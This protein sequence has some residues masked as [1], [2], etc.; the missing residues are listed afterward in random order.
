[1]LFRIARHRDSH[2]P[3]LAHPF[4]R[5]NMRHQFVCVP[6]AVLRRHERRLA[7]RRIAPQCHDPA[8]AYLR[9]VPTADLNTTFGLSIAVF[10]LIQVF[11]ISHKG[12]GGFTKEIFTAPFHAESTPMKMVLAPA[13]ASLFS[14]ARPT[15]EARLRPG[16][17]AVVLGAG[18]MGALA[19]KGLAELPGVRTVVVNRSAERAAALAEKLGVE[20]LGLEAFVAEPPRETRALVCAL[21]VPGLVGRAL[22]E[23]LPRPL[24]V[25]DLGVPR[26]VEAGAAAAV[27]ASL[28]DVEALRE[29]GAERRRQLAGQLARAEQLV[30]AEVERAMAEWTERQLAPS[31]RHLRE[32]YRATLGESVTPEEAER[33]AHKFAH[34][35][36]KGL[37]A[38]ARTYGLEAARL[39]LA[40]TGLAE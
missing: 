20:S 1:M 11:G 3:D 19:A 32:L 15:L 12:L 2:R 10:L 30:Q 24:L 39:F 21:G 17:A 6:E 40:E 9:A 26:N 23:R 22:L 28:L 13:N 33:L 27:G 34:V 35:P 36:V 8:H 29:I 18:T 5:A 25:V 16:D 14:L 4:S 7:L 37:R 38:I 31:I